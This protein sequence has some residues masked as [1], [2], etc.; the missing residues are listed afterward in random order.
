MSSEAILFAYAA[1]LEGRRVAALVGRS[2]EIGVGKAAAAVRLAEAL[3]RARPRLVVLFGVCGAYPP[4]HTAARPDLPVGALCVVAESVLADEGVAT[5]SGFR[6]LADL[7]LGS[8]EPFTADAAAS[9]AL[10]E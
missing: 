4:E 10:A 9:V 7:G 8:E 1:P 6:G 3:V 2:L 5:P